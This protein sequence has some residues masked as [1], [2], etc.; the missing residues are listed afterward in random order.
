MSMTDVDYTG[1]LELQIIYGGV[2][3]MK[4]SK[5]NVKGKDLIQSIEELS[6]AMQRAVDKISR[7]QTDKNHI[8]VKGEK[9]FNETES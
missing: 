5:K 4:T 1:D 9:E 3:F 2:P 6:I 8:P 7:G